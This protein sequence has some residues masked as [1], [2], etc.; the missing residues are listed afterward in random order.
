MSEWESSDSCLNGSHLILSDGNK[1]QS[2]A[3][4]L[5]E[6]WI[7]GL[8]NSK[9]TT[10]RLSACQSMEHLQ[11]KYPSPDFEDA[12]SRSQI[13]DLRLLHRWGVTTRAS[14][15]SSFAFLLHAV[16]FVVGSFTSIRNSISAIEY[17]NCL[18]HN[19]FLLYTIVFSIF[20]SLHFLG[21]VLRIW[22]CLNWFSS[23]N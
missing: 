21:K 19:T 9:L 12:L 6:T 17:L 23:H 15:G 1:V 20:H 18:I 13:Q 8:S 3:V 5:I 14:P 7:L 10:K 22:K 11:Y 16:F 4:L 2:W